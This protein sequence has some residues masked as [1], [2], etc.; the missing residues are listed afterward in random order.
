MGVRGPLRRWEAGY[1]VLAIPLVIV[2]LALGHL[3]PAAVVG[4]GVALSAYRLLLA[5]PNRDM[6]QS[7]WQ[8]LR[9]RRG[10]DSASG[11]QE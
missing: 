11:R 5:D 4:G 7:A 10:G 3:V 8:R 9:K 6:S 1:L 2:L